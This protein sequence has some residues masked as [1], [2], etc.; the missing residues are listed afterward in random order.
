M[1]RNRSCGCSSEIYVQIQEALDPSGNHGEPP[2]ARR[3]LAPEPTPHGSQKA[4]SVATTAEPAEVAD[5][6]FAFSEPEARCGLRC[7]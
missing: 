3:G 5:P 1:C 2:L 7:V 6:P 4:L